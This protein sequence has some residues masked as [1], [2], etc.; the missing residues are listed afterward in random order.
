MAFLMKKKK[1]KFQTTFT[2]EE[3]T[4]V[5]FVNGVLFCKVRLLD[6]G[7]FVSLSSR[8]EVQENCVRWRK[9]FAFV[10]KMSA[11]P[12]T[13]LLDPCIFRVSVRKEL[14]GGKAYSKLGFADL[15][16][17]EFAGS[18][19]TVRCCLLEG[20]D[21][22]NTRQD[23]SILKIL[24]PRLCHVWAIAKVFA[25]VDAEF[26]IGSMFCCNPQTFA[27]EVP[28]YPNPK[29]TIGMSLLSGDPCFKTP[30]STAKSISI[31]GQ[32]ASLQ[33]TCKGGGTSSG[34]SSS[35]NSLTGSRPPKVRPTILGSGLLEEPDQNLSSPEEVPHSGHSRSSS[36]A[37]QQSKVSGY[38]TE[39]S[40]SSSLSDL[41]HRR[42]TSTS[43]STSGGPGPA[44]E[45]PEGSER[46]HRP[47]EKPPRP[48]RPLHLSDRSFRR[49]KDSVE[50]HPTWV[51]DTRIDADDIVEKIMQ[52]QDFTDGSNTEDSNLRLFVSR[53]GSTTLSGIQLANRFLGGKQAQRA[54][55]CQSY[56]VSGSFNPRG[57]ATGTDQVVG[58]GLVALSLIIFTYYTV[59]VILLPFIDSEHVIHKYFLP[60]A[61]AVAIPLAVGLLLLLFVEAGQREPVSSS[62]RHRGLLRRLWDK[63]TRLGL[64]EIGPRHELHGVTRMM[65]AGLWAAT[66]VSIDHPP[67]GFE[68]GTLAGPAFARL[69]RSLGLAE[70]DYQAA[71]GPGGPYLQF[72]STSKSKASFF[73]SSPREPLQTGLDSDRILPPRSHDQRFFLKTQRRREVRVLLAHLPRYV[74][75]LQ[76]HP[77]SL[78]ARLLGVHSLRVAQGKKKYFIIMQSVFYP[79]VRISERRVGREQARGPD[80]S[81][82]SVGR[83]HTELRGGE[84]TLPG[85]RGMK[86]VAPTS[87]ISGL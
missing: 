58:L 22:K 35:T 76:R 16:L 87:R 33:L 44:V 74:Q 30:P 13:G 45:G 50:S 40:C 38:S 69:R 55:P 27:T 31:P 66:Q 81:G 63:Q 85:P 20:Y 57:Q 36:Y 73:L 86:A 25:Q 29:V 42:N 34:G 4:A 17:A 72:I 2:L 60:R 5:P 65:Q 15:N 80:L 53:D 14:K 84:E 12:A 83:R 82:H 3:L 78:L 37:S 8:E 54:F 48:P 52:S 39:H 6:G 51:D 68:L 21:T 10:C 26:L 49:K 71:L 1:F 70:E 46:E 79:A 23:N 11:N 43:S 19:S 28:V 75:H 41:T 18:G 47:P 24:G 9:R 77:H 67:T 56:L 7:D 32:D 59:W 62:S 64:F 61:Y